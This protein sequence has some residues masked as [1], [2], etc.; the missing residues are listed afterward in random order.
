MPCVTL[1]HDIIPLHDYNTGSGGHTCIMFDDVP[2]EKEKTGGRRE[3]IGSRTVHTEIPLSMS[4]SIM[5]LICKGIYK[6]TGAKRS[7][8][9][10][11]FFYLLIPLNKKLLSVTF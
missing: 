8:R 4:R 10:F 3:E 5:Y 7:L 9:Y 1:D 2:V 6:L 11:K